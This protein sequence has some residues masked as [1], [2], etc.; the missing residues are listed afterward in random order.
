[1][2]KSEIK[3]Q[4]VSLLNSVDTTKIETES[5]LIL[6]EYYRNENLNTYSKFLL[7]EMLDMMITWP[8]FNDEKYK[9]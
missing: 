6:V 2:K 7:G 5:F 3:N 8:V 4:I 1:M 9:K